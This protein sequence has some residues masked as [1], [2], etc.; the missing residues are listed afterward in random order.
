MFVLAR[1]TVPSTV[2]LLSIC[3]S[4][5]GTSTSPVP[6]ALSSKSAFDSVEVI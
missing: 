1:V 4:L 5:L 3:T 6:L 2:R